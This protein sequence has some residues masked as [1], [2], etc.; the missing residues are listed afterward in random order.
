[1]ESNSN[2]SQDPLAV[3]VV[4][5]NPSNV[6]KIYTNLLTARGRKLVAHFAFD[7]RN[8]LSRI[9]KTKPTSI[10]IDDTLGQKQISWLV[11]KI[12]KSRSLKGIA[13]TLIKSSNSELPASNGVDEL[14]LHQE[15]TRERLYQAVL[16]SLKFRKY[17]EYFSKHKRK[18][19]PSF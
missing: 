17:K 13:I 14:V 3:L 2:E 7:L 10:I 19:A 6:G 8:I 16:N 18:S 4:G 11:S 9:R 1:M 15:I 5:N 12:R